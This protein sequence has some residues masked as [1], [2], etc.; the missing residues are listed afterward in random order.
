M[1]NKFVEA[2]G[3][4]DGFNRDFETPTPYVAGTLNAFRNGRL[5]TK[6]LEDGFNELVPSTGTFRM[7]V[8]PELDDTLF[9]FYGKA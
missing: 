1:A 3:L 6:V 2:I 5:V 7:K 9:C 8:A 4:I